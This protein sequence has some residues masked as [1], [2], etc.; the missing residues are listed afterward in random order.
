MFLSSTDSSSKSTFLR[1]SFR[2]AF[3]VS[4]SLDPDQTRRFVGS[5]VVGTN[6]L[7]RPSGDDTSRRRFK[8]IYISIIFVN[9]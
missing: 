7:Q 6:S 4:K 1:N 8:Y 3:R 9:M 5:D 2:N